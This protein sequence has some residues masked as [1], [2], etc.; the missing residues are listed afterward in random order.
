MKI[1]P[2]SLIVLAALMTACSSSAPFVP[3]AAAAARTATQAARADTKACPKSVVYVSSAQNG[4]VEIYDRTKLTGDPCGSITGLQAPQGL[5]VDLTGN[6][7]VADSA[8]QRVYVF[9]SGNPGAIRTLDDPDGQPAAIAVDEKSNTVYVTEY[10]NNM[11]A[12]N[13]VQVYANGSTIPTMTLRDPSARNAGFVAVDDRGNLYVTFTTQ[14]NTAQ[15]DEWLGGSGA[16]KNLRLNLVSAGAIVTTNDGTLAI[17]DPFAYR[18]GEFAPGSKRMTHVFG[19]IGKGVPPGVKPNKRDWLNPDALAIDGAGDRAYV[20][21][22]TLSGW[23]YPGPANRPSHKPLVEVRVPGLAG[24]G[25]A[26]YPASPAGRP[27]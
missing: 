20:A 23:K 10:V 6:L 26:V 7:W 21:A 9:A 16:P 19:H 1:T 27:Y 17:C 25:I 14:S 24:N 2:L 3:S 5:F 4:T 8:T 22:E 18:C 13:L 12:S 11:D 15:V